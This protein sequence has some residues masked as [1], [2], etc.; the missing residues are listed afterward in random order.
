[1]PC[2]LSLQPV[3]NGPG[4]S[5]CPPCLVPG[6]LVNLWNTASH[7]LCSLSCRAP[8]LE[9][10]QLCQKDQPRVP[11]DFSCA[12]LFGSLSPALSSNTVL[13]TFVSLEVCENPI[14]SPVSHILALFPLCLGTESWDVAAQFE[15]CPKV[16]RPSAKQPSH[17]TGLAF[18]G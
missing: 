6:P 10:L 12:I 17:R 5:R 18:L 14:R 8:S 1:M 11:A 2:S 3:T 15:G 9:H 13:S 16:R 7:S 4:H